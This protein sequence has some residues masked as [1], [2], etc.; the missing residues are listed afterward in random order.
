MGNGLLAVL[1]SNKIG[2]CVLSYGW[3]CFQKASGQFNCIFVQGLMK[4]NFHTG[5][6]KS[7]L[8]CEFIGSKW[9]IQILRHSD[10]A[11]GFTA[12]T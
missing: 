9:I 7:F 3:P 1:C 4:R 2:A 6:G 8:Q 5:M 10:E 12:G 11:G